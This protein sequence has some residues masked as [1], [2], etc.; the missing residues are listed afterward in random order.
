MKIVKRTYTST[1]TRLFAFVIYWIITTFV[2]WDFYPEL[3]FKELVFG[4][5]YSTSVMAYVL[6]LL[7]STWQEVSYEYTLKVENESQ[8]EVS[9]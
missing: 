1:V 8:G 6:T 2:V 4:Y 3:T 7:N 5:W 9:N